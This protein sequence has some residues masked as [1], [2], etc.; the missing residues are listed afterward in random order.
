[1]GEATIRYEDFNG[2]GLGSNRPKAD[3]YQGRYYQP[4]ILQSGH[5]GSFPAEK[6]VTNMTM[7]GPSQLDRGKV[8]LLSKALQLIK[9]TANMFVIGRDVCVNH[10][11][12]DVFMP[13]QCLDGSDIR[14]CCQQVTCKTVP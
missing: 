7:L 14:A 8:A 1:M 2:V 11:R 5:M 4:R 10:R 9:R 6:T 3:L 13:K 12:L